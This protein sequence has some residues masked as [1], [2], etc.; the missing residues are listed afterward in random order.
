MHLLAPRLGVPARAMG[1]GTPIHYVHVE[2]PGAAH[3]Y[4]SSARAPSYGG[5]NSHDP[6]VPCI[7]ILMA[8]SLLHFGRGYD[9]GEA[10]ESTGIPT[11]SGAAMKLKLMITRN[12][13]LIIERFILIY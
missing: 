3:V 6:N 1:P 11:T 5:R 9:R 12:Y 2:V 8:P 4:T 13:P 7:P 10:A